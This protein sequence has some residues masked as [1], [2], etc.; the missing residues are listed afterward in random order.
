MGSGSKKDHEHFSVAP[1][2]PAAGTAE[3]TAVGTA[4]IA[5]AVQ[6]EAQSI[7][8]AYV[9]KLSQL[10]GTDLSDT[11][12]GLG[13]ALFKQTAED[14]QTAWVHASTWNGD[15]KAG[16]YQALV[17]SCA[18][19][20]KNTPPLWQQKAALAQGF[21]HPTLADIGH[22]GSLVT[23]LNPAV[24]DATKAAI[25]AKAMQRWSEIAAGS[26]KYGQSL[27]QVA[28]AEHVLTGSEPLAPSP[29]PDPSPSLDSDHSAHR[30][31][32][33]KQKAVE[34][35]LG[36]HF[37][38]LAAIPMRRDDAEVA[39]LA[40]TPIAAPAVGGAHAKSFH[41]SADGA[42]WMFKPDRQKG[43]VAE[44]EAAASRICGIGGTPSV[45]VH[46]R[47]IDGARGSFQPLLAQAN[48]LGS[49][50]SKLSQ[51][52][53]DLLVRS[54]VSSWLVGDHDCKPDN[55]L[56]TTGGGLVPVDHGQAF[57]FWGTDALS[58]GYNPN[59]PHN[60][61]R[62]LYQKLYH[63]HQKGQLAHGVRVRPEAA[64][65]V[66]KRY[67][68]VPDSE[69]REILT[70]VAREGVRRRVHWYE[71]MAARAAA[72]SGTSKPAPADIEAAFLDHAV[73]RKHELRA[74]FT[75]LF[76]DVFRTKK[77]ASAK[78]AA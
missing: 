65:G 72:T 66:I 1:T 25:H 64:L 32:L 39:A 23:W 15:E 48:P 35:A 16:L 3:V 17:A 52:D 60:H 45:P 20:L 27:A 54:H 42:Q 56:R 22:E 61:D 2:I 4:P 41:A 78:A 44:A 47:Q 34:A 69:Y 73:A 21:E 77:A 51:H 55:V 76:A 10:H 63:A 7:K 50:M 67:E 70:A 40:L 26:T 37:A 33:G 53:V 6:T 8:D 19:P 49:D 75:S 57:K 9:A 24:D 58:L 68:A 46:V 43:A 13:Y 30:T 31:F 11:D 28:A 36:H 62:T 59:Q 14:A 18:A 71:A 12:P 74:S 29:H 5:T 38:S